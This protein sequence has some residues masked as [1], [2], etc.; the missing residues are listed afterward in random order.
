MPSFWQE[1]VDKLGLD[2]STMNMI[3]SYFQ[4]IQIGL[5]IASILVASCYFGALAIKI[6]F[7]NNEEDK[8]K[9]KQATHRPLH[10]LGYWVI[11]LGGIQ[12]FWNI[13][14]PLLWQWAGM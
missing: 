5:I 14:L 9:I 8:K 12:I 2:Q 3:Y 4:Y 11:L 7:A 1:L 13:V 6:Y 10:M